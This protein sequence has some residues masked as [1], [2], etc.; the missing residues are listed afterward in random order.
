MAFGPPAAW[1]PQQLLARAVLTHRNYLTSPQNRPCTLAC[2][3]D[4]A[5]RKDMFWRFL[6]SR[7]QDTMRLH[8]RAGI[9]R[10]PKRCAQC[11]AYL[12]LMGKTHPSDPSG[13]HGTVACPAVNMPDK[14]SK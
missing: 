10:H 13:R 1:L 3:A 5:V 6:K 9:P 4:Q 8:E 12:S 11:Q 7:H 2:C 14:E